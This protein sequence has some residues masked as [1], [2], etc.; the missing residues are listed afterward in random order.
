[1]ARPVAL[2]NQDCL[3]L[4]QILSSFS[5]PITEEHAWAVIHQAVTC[6]GELEGRQEELFM[7]TEA[8]QLLFTKD[9]QV[10]E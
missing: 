4:G 9:G 3:T 7:V 5:A 8:L 10:V 1:M 6:L 2:D